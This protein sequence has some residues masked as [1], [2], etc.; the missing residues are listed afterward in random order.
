MLR[1]ALHEPH[2]MNTAAQLPIA[3]EGKWCLCSVGQ[4]PSEVLIIPREEMTLT[5]PLVLLQI[6]KRKTSVFVPAV[7]GR[8]PCRVDAVL[9]YQLNPS[10]QSLQLRSYKDTEE[11]I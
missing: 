10:L 9:Q 1:E 2:G 6:I 8:R 3:D 4:A 11:T 5:K 7:L